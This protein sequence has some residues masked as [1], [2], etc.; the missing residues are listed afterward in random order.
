M[1]DVFAFNVK[2]FVFDLYVLLFLYY[3][4]WALGVLSFA[5]FGLFL[6]FIHQSY[7]SIL[8]EEPGEVLFFLVWKKNEVADVVP[9]VGVFESVPT[10]ILLFEGHEAVVFIVASVE[11]VHYSFVFVH[12]VFLHLVYKH[13][14]SCVF[15]R[16]HN[17]FQLFD[18]RTS[19]VL[20]SL[21]QRLLLQVNVLQQLFDKP[22]SIVLLTRWFTSD[23]S[24]KVLK[25]GSDFFFVLYEPLVKL[26][27]LELEVLLKLFF[28]L[29]FVS[30]FLYID[31]L[32][33]CVLV[34]FEKELRHLP[35]N[36]P[37]AFEVLLDSG[38]FFSVLLQ[39]LLCF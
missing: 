31:Q 36:F 10:M 32:F 8:V 25:L 21:A 28:E 9:Q 27:E 17:F 2:V 16:F 22:E 4:L 6:F 15:F 13:V 26:L 39:A 37:S 7:K 1:N 5:H 12:N 30:Y 29:L 33:N 35:K 3:M 14:R 34:D 24:V 23:W 19:V 11:H 18:Q 38:E 20:H